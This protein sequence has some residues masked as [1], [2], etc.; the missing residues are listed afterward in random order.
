MPNRSVSFSPLSV[1]FSSVP[2]GPRATESKQANLTR[3]LFLSP[4]SVRFCAGKA[5]PVVQIPGSSY[6]RLG[7]TQEVAGSSPVASRQFPWV[8]EGWRIR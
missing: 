4:L 1:R 5:E 7:V 2:F 8:S 3:S 6:K